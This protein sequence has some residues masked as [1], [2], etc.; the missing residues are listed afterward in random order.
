[1]MTSDEPQ[2][3]A[4]RKDHRNDFAGKDCLQNG[5]MFPGEHFVQSEMYLQSP[6]VFEKNGCAKM[7]EILGML[8]IGFHLGGDEK[9][10]AQAKPGRGTSS[11]D[12][13]KTHLKA[14]GFGSSVAVCIA[15]QPLTVLQA[16]YAEMDD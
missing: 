13:V 9:I 16:K 4:T 15:R 3:Q 10:P 12:R 8:A 6:H 11:L 14:G 7:G 1:M 2:W 5:E